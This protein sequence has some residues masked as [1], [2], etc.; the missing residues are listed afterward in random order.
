M[1]SR[2]R[3]DFFG[4]LSGLLGLKSANSQK[5]QGAILLANLGASK[6]G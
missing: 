4:L 3:V 6:A 2:G 1:E 5:V